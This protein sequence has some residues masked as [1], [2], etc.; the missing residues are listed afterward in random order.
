MVEHDMT[1]FTGIK[2]IY[3]DVDG[4]IAL[5]HPY[6][7][8]ISWFSEKLATWFFSSQVLPE[9]QAKESLQI[10]I[11]KGYRIVILTSRPESLLLATA[12]WLEMYGMPFEKIFS[13]SNKGEFLKDREGYILIDDNEVLGANQIIFTSWSRVMEWIP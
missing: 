3:I 1:I 12:R 11:C 10:L 8:M 2:T 9:P 13:V 7:G 6:H 4:V 5:H